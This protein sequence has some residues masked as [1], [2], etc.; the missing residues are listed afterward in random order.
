MAIKE[1]IHAAAPETHSAEEETLQ[2]ESLKG[3]NQVRRSES[4]SFDA[5]CL[6]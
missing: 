2:K 5:H 1:S 6:I 4:S 3:F